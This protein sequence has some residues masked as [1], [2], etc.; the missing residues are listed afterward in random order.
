MGG[1]P[2]HFN[3]PW[4]LAIESGAFVDAGLEVEFVEVPGGTG[5]MSQMLADDRL[6]VAILLTEGGIT[7]ILNGATNRL[8]KAYTTSPLIWGIHT[9]AQSDIESVEQI[10]G[11][12]YAISRRGS[13]S[14]LMAIVDAAERDWETN[15][16]QFEIVKNLDGAREAFAAGTA[17]VFLWEKFMTMPLVDAGEFRRVGERVVPWPAFVASAT[18]KFIESNSQQLKQ[19]LS[20]AQNSAQV[21]SES[22]DAVDVISQRYDLKHEDTERWFEQTQWSFDFD[23]PKPAIEKVIRYLRELDLVPDREYELNEILAQFELIDRERNEMNEN[24]PNL[25]FVHFVLFAVNNPL[26]S[27]PTIY[28]VPKCMIDHYR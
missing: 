17:E 15:E 8:V 9:P 26:A 11:R 14:H 4:H 2:E 6:D 18:L 10:Q 5:A 25:T 7:K 1:V 16:M 13:G 12:K 19:I 20:V 28:A 27:C 23:C 21:L 24:H 3:L 22:D